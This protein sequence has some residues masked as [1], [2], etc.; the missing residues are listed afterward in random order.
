MNPLAIDS[1]R[2]SALEHAYGSAGDIPQFLRVLD[3]FPPDTPDAEPWFMLWSSL[4]HQGDVYSASFAA[5][6]W[7]VRALETNPQRATMSY[8]LFPTCVEIG[9]LQRCVPIP[10]D[11]EKDYLIALSRLGELAARQALRPDIE[12]PQLYLAAMA[13]SRGRANLAELL[14]EL[15]EGRSKAGIELFFSGRFDEQLSAD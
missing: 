13:A 10:S 15:D 4:C 8:F 5:V 7:V 3:T 1:A 14:L 11:L 9:R 12:D 6:P 2:W